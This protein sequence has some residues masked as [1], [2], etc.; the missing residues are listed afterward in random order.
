MKQRIDLNSD[1]GEGFGPWQIGDGV[2]EA[3]MPLIS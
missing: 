1:I 2:D 3:L